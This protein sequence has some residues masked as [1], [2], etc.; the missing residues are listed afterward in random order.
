MSYASRLMRREQQLRTGAA[1]IR[2]KLYQDGLP[3]SAIR[4]PATPLGTFGFARI[5]PE[6][7]GRRLQNETAEM[8]VGGL[9]PA[10][11]AGDFPSRRYLP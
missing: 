11:Q 1:A 6:D 8:P 4:W 2:R 5:P 10:G 9:G 3:G 7:V